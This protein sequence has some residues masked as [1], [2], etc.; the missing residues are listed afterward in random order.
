M[1]TTTICC[2]FNEELLLAGDQ[3]WNAMKFYSAYPRYTSLN[4]E[5]SHVSAYALVYKRFG[6]NVGQI[7]L[8]YAS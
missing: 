6:K 5:H 8:Q 2:D 4:I 1:S 3:I 7:I